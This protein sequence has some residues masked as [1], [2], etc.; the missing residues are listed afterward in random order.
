MSEHVG[1][2]IGADRRP[3]RTR[4]RHRGSPRSRSSPRWRWWPR[5]APTSTSGSGTT[6]TAAKTTKTAEGAT[7]TVDRP[8]GPAADLSQELTGGK[9]V[10]IGTATPRPGR[11]WL[12]GARV[13]RRRHGDVVQ[14]RRRARD[15]RWTF[16]PDERRVPHPS[17]RAPPATR[18]VQRHGRRRVAQRQRRSRRQ[19]RMG[20]PPRRDHARRGHVG[21][22]VGA[23]DRRRGRPGPRQ[24]RGRPGAD[25]G[26]GP[27]GDRPGALRIA[28]ASRRRVLV[29][30]LH[31]GGPGAPGRRRGSAACSPSGSSR[32]ASRS[33][34]SPW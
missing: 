10:F 12:R 15:G 8:D 17:P 31:P 4:R 22:R 21:R 24:G 18:E 25:G 3:R 20:E 28:R 30:H 34:R 27:E 5:A 1:R 29:R 16:E 11:G 7:T 23:A 14:G 13:R 19:S 2:R 6:T 33:R 9:G 26:Q 32:P